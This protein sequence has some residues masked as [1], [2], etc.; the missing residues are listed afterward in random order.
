ML[1]INA[2]DY[3]LNSSV[4]QAVLAAFAEGL[5]SSATILANGADFAQAA[6]LAHTNKLVSKLGI[7]LNLVEGTP[8][9][10]PICKLPLFCDK[11][12]CFNA[13][14][15][16]R[17]GLALSLSTQE[18]HAI[19]T[20][21]KAQI[22]KCQKAGLPISHADSHQNA[23]TRWEIW[24]V[25]APVL[26]EYQVRK[27]RLSRNC[28]GNI[29]MAKLVY[30]TLF[31]H[32]LRSAGFV[33]TDFFGDVSEVLHL[34]RRQPRLNSTSIIEAMVHP[35]FGPNNTLVDLDSTPLRP[36]IHSL[37]N[38]QTAIGYDML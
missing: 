16:S 1:I 5:C 33:T 32:Q 22:E 37:P 13:A 15:T 3:G 14:F 21:L 7:H 2:D 25:V 4:T 17:S 27:V 10:T 8:L 9:T 31:N 38:W 23:H 28:G 6:E 20:E 30:K 18:Q 11:E 19:A 26:K 35:N 34:Q 29:S 36:R 24:Q 12:G